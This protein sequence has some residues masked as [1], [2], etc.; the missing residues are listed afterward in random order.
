MKHLIMGVVKGEDLPSFERLIPITAEKPTHI[1]EWSNSE[2]PLYDYRLSQQQIIDIENA[3][4][5][6]LPK[7]LDL[8][9]TSHD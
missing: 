1:M 6:D 4:S 3:R 8:F 7:N 2:D 9:L 5:L